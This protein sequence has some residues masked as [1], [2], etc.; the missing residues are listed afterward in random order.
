MSDLALIWALL[1]AFAVLLY[2]ILDGFDLGVGILFP[3]IKD[4]SERD[5]MMNSIAPVWDGNETWL[6]MG[7]GGLY[8]AFPVAYAILLPAMY[9]LL[10]AMLLGLIFRG[11]AFEFR[12]RSVKSRR[13]W[14]IGFAGGSAVAAL[15]QGIALGAFIQGI[16]VQGRT[17]SG[18]WYDWL[19]PFSIL[20]GVS[21]VLGYALL[22]AAWLVMKTDG[23]LQDRLWLWIKPLGAAV[24]LC[25]GAVSLWTPLLSEEIAGQWFTWP[26]IL[27]KAP[28][29]VLVFIT[30]LAG[31]RA[32]AKQK[33]SQPF[34]LTI[35]LFVLCFIG[36]GVSLFPYIV[37]RAFTIGQAAA[38]DESLGF[39]LVGA[40]VLLPLI[41]TYTGYAYWVFRGKVDP[42]EG[43]H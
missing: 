27:Y 24:I 21:V 36:L 9:P 42:K 35:V 10:I 40:V 37:P 32:V 17:Y 33:D 18:G 19:T 1:L 25:I 20:T 8:A 38:P 4:E 11:V 26:N 34:Y 31:I 7:G 2:V 14:N 29:P 28:V 30:I 12:F 43:Y 15:C 41:L 5:V 6:V 13:V 39:M 3:F 16:E 23:A 22:G